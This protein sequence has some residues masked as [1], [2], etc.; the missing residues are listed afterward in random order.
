M[1]DREWLAAWGGVGREG[2]EAPEEPLYEAAKFIG[3]CSGRASR[4]AAFM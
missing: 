4:H 1:S 3:I 2:A